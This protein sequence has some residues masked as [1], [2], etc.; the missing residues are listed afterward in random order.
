MR[1]LFPTLGLK[2]TGVVH[3]LP[4]D[5]WNATRFC[6]RGMK[7][8][9][10][11]LLYLLPVL[12]VVHLVATVITGRMLNREIARLRESG[13]LLTVRQVVPAVP[14]GEQNAADLYQQ[15]FDALRLSQDEE[16][17]LWADSPAEEETHLTLAREVIAANS[18]YFDLLEEAT[19][20]AAG[21]STRK[22][23]SVR[24]SRPRKSARRPRWTTTSP[25]AASANRASLALLTRL[26][27]TRDE[28]TLHGV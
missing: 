11:V 24:R 9:G 5:I 4:R 12:V 2:V 20:T 14:P 8:L 28:T 21:R 22:R 26:A 18:C 10:R 15:A 25:S 1:G 16:S 27:P 17:K 23:L 19:R 13:E 3:E 7:K 6:G